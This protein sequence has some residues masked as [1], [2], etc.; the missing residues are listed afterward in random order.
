MNDVCKSKCFIA[1]ITVVDWFVS[2]GDV[3]RDATAETWL[4]L[5]SALK[6][7]YSKSYFMTCAEWMLC[8]MKYFNRPLKQSA[9]KKKENQNKIFALDCLSVACEMDLP[10]PINYSL[11]LFLLFDLWVFVYFVRWLLIFMN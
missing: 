11:S 9:S 3:T 5:K 6:M 10:T 8:R 4:F 1:A 2:P 7:H